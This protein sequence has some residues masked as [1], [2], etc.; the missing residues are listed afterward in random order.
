MS[1]PRRYD[2]DMPLASGETFAGHAF[3]RLPKHRGIAR[4][5]ARWHSRFFRREARP[6]NSL[7]TKL[8]DGYYAILAGNCGI[9]HNTGDA[10]TLTVGA[11]PVRANDTASKPCPPAASP[12]RAP[13]RQARQAA[14]APAAAPQRLAPAAMG[15]GPATV[16]PSSCI[17]P[18]RAS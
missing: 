17:P 7:L 12:I 8:G 18:G 3:L 13:P 6:R 5:H 11:S 14:S 2:T 15:P 10:G 1:G 16:V 4:V 9:A